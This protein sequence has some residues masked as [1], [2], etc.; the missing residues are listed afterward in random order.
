MMKDGLKMPERIENGFED[1][2]AIYGGRCGMDLLLSREE[3][4]SLVAQ[5]ADLAFDDKLNKMDAVS[6]IE[7][8]LNAHKREISEMEKQFGPVCDVIQ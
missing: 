7:I 2:G 4:E 5:V 6:I 8:C 1:L 3:K